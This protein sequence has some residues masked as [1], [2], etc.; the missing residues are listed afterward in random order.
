[1]SAQRRFYGKYDGTVTSNA[2]EENRGRIRAKVPAIFDEEES[3]W[4]LP[5]TPYAGPGV[6]FFFVPPIG[7]KVW[8][9]FEDGN[10]EHPIWTGCYW[11]QGDGPMMPAKAETKIIKTDTTTLKL[12]DMA[13]A[14]GITI[15]TTSGLKIVMN[16]YGIELSNGAM[17]IKLTPGSVAVN[18]SALVVT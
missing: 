9:E 1:M 4:A 11:L 18:E 17:S 10:P 16:V 7:A 6:G 15:E 5:C 3:G 2:D 8:I 13:G 14:E 12:D